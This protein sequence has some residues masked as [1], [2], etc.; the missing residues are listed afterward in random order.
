MANG[1]Y[2]DQKRPLTVSK[3]KI[4]KAA[5]S[6]RHGV[7]GDLRLEAIEKIQNFREFHLYPLML[8]KN[9]LARTAKKVSPQVI[10]AR[11]LKRLPTIINKLERS[12]LDGETN[13]AIKL[14]RMQDIAGCRAIV[15]NKLELYELKKKLENS[16]S[17]HQ[18]VRTTNYLDRPKD[19]G[20]GGLHLVYSCYEGKK[21]EHPWKGTNVEV[22]LRT[23]LQHAWAT[24]LEIIDTLEDIEL[25]TSIT[26]SLEWRQFF[27]IAG[28]LVAHEEELCLLEKK[29]H[30]A[31]IEEFVTLHNKLDVSNKLNK[32]NIAI[33]ASSKQSIRSNPKNNKDLVL[34]RMIKSS[35]K[36][37][38]YFVSLDYFKRNQTD[39]ALNELNKSELEDQYDMSVLVSTEGVRSLKKAY[40]NYFGSTFQFTNFISRQLSLHILH[41]RLHIETA[42]KSLMQRESEHGLNK[43]EVEL[44]ETLTTVLK[45]NDVYL[46]EA[47]EVL[48]KTNLN[49]TL[50]KL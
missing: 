16:K 45:G 43:K 24:S 3:K 49:F 35:R 21:A 8:M 40:P 11:R 27:K 30:E 39:A 25:K 6:I 26:G 20:Y 28:L 5:R 44:K 17:I 29:E 31:V 34:V 50:L 9:H 42:L 37:N 18:I 33:S 23:T 36:D 4:E 38:K 41:L 22:Q 10:V 19:S 15:K 32:Y 47:N 13:N 14:V 2:E 48:F 7:T 1:Q 46:A 12:T